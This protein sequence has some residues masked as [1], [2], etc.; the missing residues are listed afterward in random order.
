MEFGEYENKA[1]QTA[2]YPKE[3]GLIY[4]VLGLTGE[5]GEVANKVK[6]I[7][8]DEAGSLALF[9]TCS[10]V[11]EELGDVL[12]YVTMTARELGSSLEEVAELNVNKLSSRSERGK[13]QGSGDER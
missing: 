7:Y 4:C 12:W 13:L 8:R 9:E 10:F 6:K 3:I 5:S 1:K 2:I 11:L